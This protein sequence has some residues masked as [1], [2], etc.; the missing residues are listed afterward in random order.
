VLI[1]FS[2]YQESLKLILVDYPGM[3]HEA[4]RPGFVWGAGAFALV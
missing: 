1:V 2:L 3:M 4:T